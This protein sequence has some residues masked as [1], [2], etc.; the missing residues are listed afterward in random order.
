[1]TFPGP[2]GYAIEFTTETKIV[3]DTFPFQDCY[4]DTCKGTLVW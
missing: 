3:P 1:M 2:Q 4:M